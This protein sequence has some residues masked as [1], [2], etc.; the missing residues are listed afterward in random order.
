MTLQCE[1]TIG[2]WRNLLECDIEYLRQQTDKNYGRHFFDAEVER[3]Q[4]VRNRLFGPM[5]G[6]PEYDQL[7]ASNPR[8]TSS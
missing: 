3:L 2:Y 4:I 5:C 8:P 1:M 7:D 6:D